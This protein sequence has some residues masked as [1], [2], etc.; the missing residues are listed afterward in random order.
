NGFITDPVCMSPEN[1]IS[2]I[3][4][5]R[6][7]VSFTSFPVT[8]NGKPGSRLLGLVTKRDID[9]E[10]D[11]RRPLSEVMT[12]DLITVEEGISLAKANQILKECKKGKLLVVDK[13]YNLIS[14]V[15]RQDISKSN[16]FP[17]AS[18]LNTNKQLLV[19]AALSTRKEDKERLESL[20]SEG[21]DVVVIDSAQGFSSYQI[22]MVKFIKKEYPSLQVIGGNI[23]TQSQAL[24]LIEAGAD[25]LRVGMGPGSICIT[26]ETMACGRGQAT[27][28]FHTSRLAKKYG[29]PVIADGGIS[30][31][32]DLV[33]AL[34]LGGSVGMMGGLLAGTDEAPGEFYYRNGV[35]LKRYRGMASLDAMKQGG[36]KRYMAEN[37]D[38]K[39][40]QGVSGSVIARGSLLSFIPYLITGIKQA[41]Q[42]L[43][44]KSI[45]NAHES[46]Y[47]GIIRMEKRSPSSQLE[48]KVHHLYDYENPVI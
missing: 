13:D 31:I 23:V 27:A 19:G 42:D 46:L 38:I 22:E 10:T 26:Q 16:D 9:M 44:V 37:A 17:Q 2:D 7:N 45:K 24:A 39:V 35:R 14:M 5:L 33:K 28:V 11:R 21:L 40:A 8:K 48:G 20:H 29:V 43:G 4:Q 1:R 34:I 32:G 15:S 3:D 41:F 47:K 30:S 36:D 12:K 6:K 18:K 25:G